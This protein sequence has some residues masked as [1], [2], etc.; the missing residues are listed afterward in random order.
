MSWTVEYDDTLKIIVDTYIGRCTGQDFKD[1]A[2]KRIELAEEVGTTRTL[3]DASKLLTDSSTTLDVYKIADEIYER[4]DDRMDWK[5]AITTPESPAAREQA[6]FFVNV[7]VNRGWNV[8]EFTE[9]KDA[10]DWLL[11]T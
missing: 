4:E 9:R 3:I 1:V 2:K 11:S 5:L 7:C 8:K 6:R 10:I